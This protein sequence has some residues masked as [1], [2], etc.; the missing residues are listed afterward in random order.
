MRA[1]RMMPHAVAVGSSNAENRNATSMQA[2]YSEIDAL[3]V[4]RLTVNIPGITLT[5][6]EVVPWSGS[7]VLNEP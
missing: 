7:G 1:E 5:T 2:E 6:A 3:A 4:E